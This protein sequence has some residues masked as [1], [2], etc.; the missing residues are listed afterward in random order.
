MVNPSFPTLLKLLIAAYFKTVLED[1][2]IYVLC[3]QRQAGS[4]HLFLLAWTIHTA[5]VLPLHGPSPKRS[6]VSFK[7]RA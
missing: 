3:S 4:Q 1:L 7:A 6:L 2:Y 5:A